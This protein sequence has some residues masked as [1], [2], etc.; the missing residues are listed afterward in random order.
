MKKRIITLL[1]VL[2]LLVVCAV[3]AVQAEDTYINLE[4]FN[5]PCSQCNGAPYTGEWL[6]TISGT[7][8]NGD[9]Y[10][11]N[12]HTYPGTITA[13]AGVEAVIVLDNAWLVNINSGRSIIAHGSGAKLHLIGNGEN[14]A[15]SNKT[16]HSDDGGLGQVS[17]GGEMH[18]YGDLK[19]YMHSGFTGST[20]RSGL[21]RMA[22]G[23]VHIHDCDGMGLPTDKDPVLTAP[24]MTGTNK[25]G[26]VSMLTSASD[27]FIM[28]A[29]TLK[30]SPSCATGA[31][32]YNY[33]GNVQING[34][35]IAGGNATNRAGIIH[36]D[37][38]GTTT[39][40]GGEFYS[41]ADM[42]GSYRG[43]VANSGKVNFA[44]GTIISA[45]GKYGD[46]IAV[47]NGTLTLSG[48]A[49]VQSESGNNQIWRYASG[50]GVIQVDSEWSGS[51]T[52]SLSGFTLQDAGSTEGTQHL[53]GFATTA[54]KFGTIDSS[55]NFMEGTT[56]AFTPI[57]MFLEYGT[58]ENPQ[59]AGYE[60]YVV[61]MSAQLYEDGVATWYTMFG[62]AV[63]AYVKSDAASKYI[64]VWRG[65][66]AV[67]IN[68]TVY[69]DL[70]GYGY[71]NATLGANGKVYAFDSKAAAG[72][73]GASINV[74]AQPY[75]QINGKT[76]VVNNGVVYPVELKIASV[77][78]RPSTDGS[79]ASMYYTASI[80]A[81]A[82]AGIKNYGVAVTVDA[83]ADKLT[84]D[85]LYTQ[86]EGTPAAEYNGVLVQNIAA[87]GK[88]GNKSN[89]ETHI[90]AKAYVTLADDSVCF[91]TAADKTL[92][93]VV[94]DVVAKDPTAEG[95]T[96]AQ[97]AAV[98][99]MKASAWY[100]E[101]TG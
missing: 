62:N 71:S 15:I 43:I 59:V 67:T 23:K 65:D 61:P 20:S 7:P 27:T 55:Y 38:G 44:G 63:E 45:D 9:H 77:S 64:K 10:Y 58:H 5:C 60:S 72:E 79:S 11:I 51:A 66:K 39:I 97:I 86:T 80:K 37:A 36:N 95:W 53:A 24:A 3:F 99:A 14:A 91:S 92:A 4:T 21:I 1:A 6:T 2:A 18:L 34:G 57:N 12:A 26:G 88:P 74:D 90:Y 56:A 98:T 30:G 19:L 47:M 16:S 32:L 13:G 22:G 40:T 17:G 70:N 100:A 68:T 78:L 29:G 85:Y 101:I 94:A 35:T 82:E 31:V 28:D 69:V 89:A 87:N 75:T 96:G 52:V 84:E 81:A 49:T 41:S 33:A 76:Y 73:A 83:E 25:Y 54:V 93:Q 42:T 50:S 46:G 8:A 48:N